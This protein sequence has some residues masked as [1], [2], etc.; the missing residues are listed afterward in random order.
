MTAKTPW[1][2]FFL[3][4]SMIISN[5]KH[6]IIVKYYWIMGCFAV[7]FILLFI[8]IHN[9]NKELNTPRPVYLTKN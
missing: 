4:L 5:W 6:F 8:S 2:F 7:W 1:F 9:K 3:G